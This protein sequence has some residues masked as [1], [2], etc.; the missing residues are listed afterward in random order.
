MSTSEPRRDAPSV[1]CSV[2]VAA[3][4]DGFIAGPAGEL[5]WLHRPE[6]AQLDGE[7]FGF[8]RFLAG[9]DVLV[10]G[11]KTF[12][13]VRDF[14]PWP[15][16]ETPV[17]VLS[18][19]ELQVPPQ[20]AGRVRRE[21]APPAELVAR[22]AAGGARHLYVDGGLTVQRFLAAGRVDEL[23]VTWIPILLGG[24]VTLFGE[25]G[26]EVALDLVGVEAFDNGFVQCKYRARRPPA[27]AGTAP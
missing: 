3:S 6:Y 23:T 8:Q 14:D 16:A 21:D 19:R 20:L 4:L 24:G 17:V 26:V 5:D 22:L 15:Y 9:V 18:S 11:R 12:E 10:M 13:A 7:D 25:L 27:A 1:R 2:F